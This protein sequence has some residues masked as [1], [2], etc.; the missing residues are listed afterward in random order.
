MNRVIQS[1][2]LFIPNPFNAYLLDF[3]GFGHLEISQGLLTTTLRTY[4]MFMT[5]SPS[6]TSSIIQK[7]FGLGDV[8]FEITDG[9]NTH[10]INLKN[11]RHHRH[12]GYLCCQHHRKMNN[13]IF[14]N[15]NY[16]QEF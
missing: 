10:H 9:H 14:S 6:C 13:K 4:D 5:T 11:I 2:F 15:T 1:Y 16:Y 8:S 7:L 12:I 3:D